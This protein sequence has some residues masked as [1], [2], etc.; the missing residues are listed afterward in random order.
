M[1][2]YAGLPVITNK[3]PIEERMGVPHHLLGCVGLEEN[4]WT[5]GDFVRVAGGVVRLSLFL[6]VG[7]GSV[8]GKRRY[9]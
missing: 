7:E 3:M 9:P 4:P 8:A 5:V 2:L 1:Q 6:R